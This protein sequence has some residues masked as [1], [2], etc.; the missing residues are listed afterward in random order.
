MTDHDDAPAAADARV[1]RRVGTTRELPHGAGAVWRL[2]EPTRGLDANVIVL[3]PGDAIE[4]HD[5]PGLDV[6]VHV[7]DGAGLL[8]RGDRDAP[9]ELRTGDLVWLPGSARRGYTA[10]SDG[11][12]YFSVHARKSGLQIGRRPEH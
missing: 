12:R 9:V 7:L 1:A 6:L 8:H 2:A 5:G 10:G 11:L 3:P 4:E